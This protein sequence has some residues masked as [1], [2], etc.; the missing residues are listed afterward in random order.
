MITD[1]PGDAAAPLARG[2]AEEQQFLADAGAALSAATGS[3]A[4][5]RALASIAV[6]FLADV[7]HVHGTDGAGRTRRVA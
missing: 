6:P 1:F 7:C 5:L 3:T 4:R 2:A